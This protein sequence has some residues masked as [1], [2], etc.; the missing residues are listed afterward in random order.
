MSAQPKVIRDNATV[1]HGHSHVRVVAAGR[2]G[3][4]DTLALRTVGVTLGSNER[5][6]A[7]VVM[8]YVRGKFELEDVHDRV[9][10]ELLLA[11]V[12]DQTIDAIGIDVP[13]A[14]PIAL[15]ERLAAHDRPTAVARALAQREDL[16]R[17]I[18]ARATDHWVWRQVPGGSSVLSTAVVK[19]G[20]ALVR[21]AWLFGHVPAVQFDRTGRSGCFVET[22]PMA[23][24]RLLELTAAS[25]A[26]SA[27]GGREMSRLA[28]ALQVC[29]GLDPDVVSSMPDGVADAL[30]SAIVAALA[31]SGGTPCIP[32]DV[33]ADARERGWIHLPNVR[34]TALA[35]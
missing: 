26:P 27:V 29:Y 18:D 11:W 14:W 19:P 24:R 1:R 9:T 8:R 10:D 17:H 25:S 2:Y 5:S 6:S 20:G 33:V 16:V 4:A 34:P 23:M 31:R 21:A 7:A 15:C 12:A 3:S 22:A 32:Q 28:A 35:S 13:M 30:L